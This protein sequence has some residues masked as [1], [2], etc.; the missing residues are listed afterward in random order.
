MIDTLQGPHGLKKTWKNVP[1]CSF[2]VE[3]PPYQILCFIHVVDINP[4]IFHF[5]GRIILGD[6][7]RMIQGRILWG[8]IIPRGELSWDEL[9]SGTNYPGANYPV[10][11]HP[12][13][14]YPGVNYPGTNYPVTSSPIAEVKYYVDCG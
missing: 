14:N 10:A 3:D 11:N 12:G 4:A 2:R 5:W 7:L 6:E 9:S 13:T 1:L 8:G